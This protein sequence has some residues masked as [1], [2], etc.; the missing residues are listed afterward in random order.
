MAEIFTVSFLTSVLTAAVRA[1]TPLLFALLGEITVERSGVLNLGVEGM[2]IVGALA[3]FTGA[4]YFG[5]P[6]IGLL[7]GMTAGGLLALAHGFLS[8]T[9]KA[10]QPVSG[11]MLVLLGLG[12]TSFLGAPMAGKC[13]TKMVGIS[14]P[15]LCKVPVFGPALFQQDIL[16]Y[17]SI[18]LVPVLWLLLYRSRWGLAIIATGENP[19]AADSLGVNVVRVRYLCVLFGGLL[20]GVGGAYLTVAYTPMWVD[21]MTA[22]R[23]WIVIALVIFAFWDPTRAV[24]G[25]YFF[26]GIE[27]FQMRL[28]VIGIGVPVQLLQM[29]P[30]LSTL[31]ILVFSAK[32]KARRR[33]GAPAALGVPYEREKAQ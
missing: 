11:I 1:G 25:A 29:L 24:V 18:L 20:A 2:M 13:I 16:V 33:I 6:W 32:Q 19:E 21:G 3:G 26:G 30:Y 31:A 17:I 4:F 5:N 9:L 10:E 27:A 12:L 8:I 7:L 23:G 22:G 15:Y 14:V 28:Q